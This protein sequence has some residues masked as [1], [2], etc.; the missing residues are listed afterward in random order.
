MLAPSLMESLVLEQSASWR[1]PPQLAGAR[2]SGSDDIGEEGDWD[3]SIPEPIPDIGF[4]VSDSSY[5]GDLDYDRPA[6]SRTAGGGLDGEWL[7]SMRPS[8]FVEQAMM[9]PDKASPT[10]LSPF[11]FG[12]RRYLEAIYN[13][14]ARNILLMAG[15]QVEK[16]S[17]LAYLLLTQSALRPRFNSLYV[18]PSAMQTKEFSKMKLREAIQSSPIMTTWFPPSLAGNTFEAQA[19]NQSWIK[20]R[21]AFLTADRCRGISTDFVLLDEFQDFLLDNIG[22]IEHAASHSHFKMKL[23]AGTPKSKDN[24]IEYQWSKHSTQCEWVVPC[25]RHGTGPS[26]W[27]WQRLD[28]SNIGDKGLIC[29]K[30]GRP[31]DAM[32]PAAEWVRTTDGK[33]PHFEGYR[34]P[35]L[36]V[37]WVDWKEVL[38][39]R[40]KATSKSQFYNECLGLSYDSGQRPITRDE[41]IRACD[42]THDMSSGTVQ[43]IIKMLRQSNTPIYAG[44]DWG[45]ES[46]KSYTVLTLGAYI[47][48]TFRIFFAQRFTGSETE[49]LVQIQIIKQFIERLGVR[50]CGVDYGGGFESNPSLLSAFGSER[51]QVYQYGSSST[52]MQ[53]NTKGK[54]W[55]VHRTAVMS[56]VFL[57]LKSGRLRLPRWS[58]GFDDPYG[59]DILSI[60]SEYSEE[61]R[62]TTYGKPQNIP[63]D[64]FHSILYC[65]LASM[66]DYPRPD[67]FIP[68]AAIDRRLAE[69]AI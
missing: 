36:M 57:A 2:D 40:D 20:L 23:Y 11:S 51:I 65:F 19:V 64:T 49:R 38:T 43:G 52:Y 10:G 4:D 16:S 37:P 15:R 59:M 14:R 53:W 56:A 62:T 54:H 17:T 35:Q 66:R 28:E 67:L 24:P 69:A 9:V 3:Q 7:Y 5:R 68:S 22:I 41:L 50:V 12:K 34:I 21:Y 30:C 46:T 39:L 32:H 48:K 31:I 33:D 1:V 63:D 25:E 42:P 44:V 47:S 55:I 18:T 61:R 27:Y 26:S 8:D 45:Q 29:S 6:P 13:S 60:F 58:N